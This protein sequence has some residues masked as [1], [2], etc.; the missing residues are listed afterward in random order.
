MASKI[1]EGIFYQE[2]A[3]PGKFF[4]I[5][6]LQP[7]PDVEGSKVYGFLKEL[8]ELYSRLKRGQ[9]RDLP[10]H[11]VP[12]G[13]LTVLIGF[14]PN[15]FKIQGT[16]S[17]PPGL[18]PSNRFLS[19]RTMGG[20]PLLLNSGLSYGEDIQKNIATEAVAI[21]FIAN[22]QLAVN[23]AI[24]ETWKLLFDHEK[25]F[26]KPPPVSLAG[27]FDGFQ[28]DD[29]RS[30]I[31]FHDGISNLRSGSERENAIRIKDGDYEN[32]TFM[33]FLRLSVDL[34]V[35]RSLNNTQQEILVGRGKLSG[36]PL[37]DIQNEV[38]VPISSCPAENTTEITGPSNTQFREPPLVGNEMLRQSHV[39]RANLQ[40]SQNT[41]DPQSL[42]IFRQG[43]EFMEA[44]PVTPT[45]RVGLNFV[46]FQ[47]TPSRIIR[48]L[49][50]QRWLGKTNFGGDPDSPLPG[51]NN[52]LSVRAAAIFLVPPEVEG[53]DFPGANI[54]NSTW[55]T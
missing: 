42:R 30:W 50:R 8:W 26:S 46:S 37:S 22:S 39:Q 38:P 33:C 45:F 35:W 19:P 13:E 41:D 44:I 4:A 31:D 54:F 9:V 28:R 25:K 2:G 52:L 40:H 20:G 10:E 24:V 1:Q 17:T 29:S 32:G 11:P 47:D 23:R 36:C 7:E 49:T 53:E 34:P 5:A 27:F 48:L 6:F 14:G 12:S 16:K 3:R 43:Y 21:Q 18:S 55:S 15:A 51:M